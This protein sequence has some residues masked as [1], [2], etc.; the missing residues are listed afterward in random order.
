MQ[1]K[2]RNRQ[3][4]VSRANGPRRKTACWPAW[5]LLLV[6]AAF[7]P[8]LGCTAFVMKGW[9]GA[10]LAKNLDGPVG[11]G[12]VF[13]N[14][15]NVAKTA[16]PGESPQPLRWTSKYG[17]VTF[18]QF[19][20][21]FPLGGMNEAGLVVEELNAPSEYPLLDRRPALNAFQWV[22]YQ[23]DTQASVKGVLDSDSR[24]RVARFLA[25]LHYLVTDRKGNT[26]VIEFVKGRMV[27]YSGQDLPVR[28]L[29]NN[30]Y[31]ESL[32]YL[33][34][35]RGFGGQRQVSNGPEPR[36]R[37]VRAASLLKDLDLPGQRP[38]VDTAFLIL[39]SVA[40]EDTQWSIV[41]YPTRGLVFFK[42]KASRR[43]KVIVLE[44]FDFRCSSPVLM[45]PILAEYGGRLSR[46]FT[47]YD[48]Q[49]NKLLLETVFGWLRD[50]GDIAT[51]LP[52]GM[53]RKM[54]DYPDGCLCRQGRE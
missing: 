21:E 19:G 16:C 44:D 2:G 52:A 27:A 28:A 35:H 25:G 30:S 31:A 50:L 6:L 32:R 47:A 10:L 9:G 54:A 48:P 42:T 13:V 8:G 11:E 26:A 18:N 4:A 46:S 5:G 37:F 20:R 41:Y 15:K 51:S 14:K 39:R 29:A 45:L 3:S 17:S 49:K 24:L 1:K 23:L 34:F 12:Y 53:I 33:K 40:Q 36:E 7:K 22:Q 43:L 38:S